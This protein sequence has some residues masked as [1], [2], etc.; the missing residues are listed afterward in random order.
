MSFDIFLVCF[1]NGDAAP[2]KREVFEAIFLP[3]C[4][5]VRAYKSDP[6]FMRVEY[7]DGSGGD[8]YCGDERDIDNIMFNHCG[9]ESFFNDMFDLA[10]RTLSI[11]FWPDATPVYVYTNAAVLKELPKDF[12]E[13]GDRS[14]LVRSGFDIVEAIRSS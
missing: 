14:R 12:I 7:R 8:I 11:I 2:F 10:D 13:K 1:R 3:H 4:D 6:S 9:G 5:N